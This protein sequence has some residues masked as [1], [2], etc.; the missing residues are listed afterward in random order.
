MPKS[1]RDLLDPKWKGEIVMP[2]PLSSGTANMMRY[3][4]LA[5][6]GTPRGGNSSRPSTRTSTTTP[7]AA[8][9]TDLVAAAIHLGLT[10]D[11]TSRS[12]STTAIRSS[13]GSAEGTGMTDLRPDL[14]GDEETRRRRRSSTCWKTRVQR[15]HGRDRVHDPPAAANALY[16]RRC[17]STSNWI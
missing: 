15:P 17:P 3:S 2:S 14:E 8:M 12:V 4:F 11:E 6:Y 1:W 9:P 7:A 10:S 13:V 16:G 5:L